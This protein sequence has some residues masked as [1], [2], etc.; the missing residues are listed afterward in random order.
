MTGRL[1]AFA[2]ANDVRYFLFNFTDIRGMRRSR[3]APAAARIGRPVLSSNCCLARALR[4]EMKRASLELPVYLGGRLNQV[5]ESS[6]TSL[7]VDVSA[8]LR[9]IGCRPCAGVEEMLRH[10]TEPEREA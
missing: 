4:R 7:P 1:E 5:P 10:L 8:Q 9:E 6:N 2:K 3:L